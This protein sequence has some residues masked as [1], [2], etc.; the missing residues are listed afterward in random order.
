MPKLTISPAE[1]KALL[2]SIVHWCRDIK[3]PLLRGMMIVKE[4]SI[5]GEYLDWY[6]PPDNPLKLCVEVAARQC[7]LC[8]FHNALEDS[9][10]S[11]CVLQKFYR[12]SCLAGPSSYRKFCENPNL[13]TC[14][15]M[16]SAMV[17]IVRN[18]EVE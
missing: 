2:E 7:P 9:R 10:C 11:F 14:N 8:V 3:V 16:I 17:E 4:K 6:P 5:F 13:T 1:Y 12:L 18:V 15:A